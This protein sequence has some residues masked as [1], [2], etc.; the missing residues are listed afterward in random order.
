MNEQIETLEHAKNTILD[1][2]I[3][4][5]PKLLAALLVLAAGVMASRWVAQWLERALSRIE[6]RA[7]R[8]PAAHARRATHDLRA[9][10]D[11]GA[12]EPGG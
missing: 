4:F 9:L 12:A 2:I 1:L 6:L 10:P 11:H 7:A 5:G 8:A 3:R